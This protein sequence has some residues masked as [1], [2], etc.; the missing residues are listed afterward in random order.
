[1]PL[2]RYLLL[3]PL[4]VSA[5]VYGQKEDDRMLL[6]STAIDVHTFKINHVLYTGML[7][8]DYFYLYD[9]R[10]RTLLK[11]PNEYFSFE[12]KDYNGDGYRDL[13]LEVG[14]NTP[15]KMEVYLYSPARHGFQELKDARK[16]PAAERIKGTSYYYSYHRGGCADLIW[17]S[18]LFYIHNSAAVALGSI[19]GEE[20][21]IEEGVYIYKI[22]AGKKQ[23]V[24]RLPIKTIYAYKDGKWGFI[25]AY[26]KKYYKRFI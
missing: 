16:F 19:Y 12:F 21:K 17:V 24:T 18:D 1:M 3:V 20:C 9:G 8:R 25:A 15:E 11:L 26:W 13:V 22:H 10:G 6:D 7:K 4:L 14:S 23:L 2:F 5:L